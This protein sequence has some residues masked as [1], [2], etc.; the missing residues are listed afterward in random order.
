MTFSGKPR[1]WKVE[2]YNPEPCP[3]CL[4]CMWSSKQPKVPINCNN[5]IQYFMDVVTLQKKIE[6]CLR[7][8]MVHKQGC[9]PD[10][11]SMSASFMRLPLVVSTKR[12][13]T[14]A[15]NLWATWHNY[16]MASGSL[17]QVIWRFYTT[18]WLD[19]CFL[20]LELD[21]PAQKPFVM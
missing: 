13:F 16:L 12:S 8:F 10:I 15:L 5:K 17:F 14:G 21:T 18:G 20:I 3:N 11:I 2:A 1:I 4:N 6:N 19:I 9:C 7:A